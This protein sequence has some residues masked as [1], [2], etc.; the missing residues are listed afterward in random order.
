MKL[1]LIALLFLIAVIGV[2]I[3]G[4][5]LS[6]QAQEAHSQ[7]T[8]KEKEASDSKAKV[9]SLQSDVETH[10]RLIKDRDTTIGRLN[11]DIEV[12]K[13]TSGG[14]A[15]RIARLERNL[16]ESEGKM[17]GLQ[18]QIEA[19]AA[20]LKVVVK[21]RPDISNEIEKVDPEDAKRLRIAFDRVKL[22]RPVTR[23]PG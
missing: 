11:M 5:L 6:K 23:P 10:K 20:A 19:Y 7:L 8:V 18:Q 2:P 17:T 13:S 3:S 22:N 16:Q 4:I 21:H 1:Q 12:L 14:A 9:D 15:E